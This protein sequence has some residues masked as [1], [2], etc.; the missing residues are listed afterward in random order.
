[1]YN[2]QSCSGATPWTMPTKCVEEGGE[3]GELLA[4]R[5]LTAALLIG[6]IRLHSVA[7]RGEPQAFHS[8]G[9][10]GVEKVQHLDPVEPGDGR[11]VG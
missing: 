6:L 9:G 10:L 5:M 4:S 3:K 8:G 2:A 7:R 11:K 1:M